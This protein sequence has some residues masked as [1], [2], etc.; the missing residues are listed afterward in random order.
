MDSTAIA[1]TSQQAMDSAVALISNG[2]LQLEG[3]ERGGCSIPFPQRDLH[4][5]DMPSRE[6]I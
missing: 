4:V 5:V 1:N 2:G 3:L 6:A